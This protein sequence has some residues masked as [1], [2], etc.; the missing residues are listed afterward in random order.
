MQKGIRID[1]PSTPTWTRFNFISITTLEPNLNIKNIN[2]KK[3]MTIKIIEILILMN[4][5]KLS[6]LAR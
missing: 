5:K 1:I 2:I 3:S 6:S 4:N